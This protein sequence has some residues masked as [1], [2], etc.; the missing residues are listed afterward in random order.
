MLPGTKDKDFRD[1]L[2][3]YIFRD[4]GTSVAEDLRPLVQRELGVEVNDDNYSKW[5]TRVSFALIDLRDEG[6]L[7]SPFEERNSP[8]ARQWIT[9][10]RPGRDTHQQVWRLTSIGSTYLAQLGE[11][12]ESIITLVPKE[13]QRQSEFSVTDIEDARNKIVASIVS[14]RGQPRFREQMLSLYNSRCAFTGADAV[15]ALE[16]AHIIPYQ[17]DYT[18]HP[19]NGLLLRADIHTLF[20]FGLLAVQTSDMTAIVSPQISATV[21]ASF[22]GQPLKLPDKKDNWPSV[23]ALDRHRSDAGL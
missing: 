3:R 5:N 4:G 17:G 7:V 2:L 8:A 6:F 14:R 20:D 15:E 1:A 13:E 22:H 21:Y 19:S 16:A 12:P 18:N 10:N 23:A 9:N 11:M